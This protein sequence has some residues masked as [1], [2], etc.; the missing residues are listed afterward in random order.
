MTETEINGLLKE[1]AA[2][3]VL[4]EQK[5]SESDWLVRYQKDTT[6]GKVIPYFYSK[7]SLES[8][9]YDDKGNTMSAIRCYTI[10]SEQKVEEFKGIEHC[11][12][13]KDSSGRLINVSIPKTT[14]SGETIYET[15]ALTTETTTDQDAYKN[16]MNQY[17]YDKALYDQ[18]VEK[19]N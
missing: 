8:A 13:E 3:K 17:E 2:W 12:I 1:E 5:Y 18:A 7:N 14:S 10:G 4:L 9:V 11:K 19:I 15:Y 16:A 6:L